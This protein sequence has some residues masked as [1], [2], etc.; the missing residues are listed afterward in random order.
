[1][2]GSLVLLPA[3]VPGLCTQ[4]CRLQAV[5]THMG[6]ILQE[7]TLLYSAAWEALTAMCHPAG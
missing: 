1:M 7:E 2:H 4:V 3:A 6:G 5:L